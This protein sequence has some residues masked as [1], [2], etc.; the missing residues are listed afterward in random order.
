MF[1]FQWNKEDWTAQTDD[2]RRELVPGV[3]ACCQLHRVTPRVGAKRD[4]SCTDRLQR[5]KAQSI[6]TVVAHFSS[7]LLYVHRDHKDY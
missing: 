1:S 7:V 6:L 2:R 4:Q 3:S 5:N